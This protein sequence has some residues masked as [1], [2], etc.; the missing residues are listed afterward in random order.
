MSYR[1]GSLHLIQKEVLKKKGGE[2]SG[3]LPSFVGGQK[4]RKARGTGKVVVLRYKD[5]L[6]LSQCER[7]GITKEKKINRQ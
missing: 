4:M 6:R 3:Q 1:N 2:C 7:R 5:E